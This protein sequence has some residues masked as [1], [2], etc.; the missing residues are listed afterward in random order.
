MIYMLSLLTQALTTGS[1][2]SIIARVNGK[3]DQSF[4]IDTGAEVSSLPKALLTKLGLSVSPGG[5][6]TYISSQPRKQGWTKISQLNLGPLNL[7]NLWFSTDTSGGSAGNL[8][9]L[10]NDVLSNFRLSLNALKHLLILQ[11]YPR[12]ELKKMQNDA[13]ALLAIGK[14]QEVVDE[15]SDCIK[16]FKGNSE[17]LDLRARAYFWLKQYNKCVE[18][19][20]HVIQLGCGDGDIYF[21]RARAYEKLGQHNLAVKIALKYLL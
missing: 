7:Q 3:V 14:Y 19:W 2:P 11:P 8:A 21:M 17:L 5:E 18:D 16:R 4:V 10:G 20:T 9:I 6:Y 12:N 13:R 1:R 15:V